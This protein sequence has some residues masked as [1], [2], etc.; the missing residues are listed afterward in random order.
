M[1]QKEKLFRPRRRDAYRLISFQPRQKQKEADSASFRVMLHQ[2]K[3]TELRIVNL[4]SCNSCGVG[5]PTRPDGHLARPT[6]YLI[7]DP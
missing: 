4:L 2:C 3:L 6:I 5:V 7:R 1:R